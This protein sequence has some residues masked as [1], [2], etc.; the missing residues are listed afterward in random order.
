MYRCLI[1]MLNC[2]SGKQNTTY[3]KMHVHCHGGLL[4]FYLYIL[5]VIGFT[6][7]S[8]R[9]FFK[10]TYISDDDSQLAY[11]DLLGWGEGGIALQVTPIYSI[12][13]ADTQTRTPTKQVTK[14]LHFKGILFFL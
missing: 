13:A 8:L 12:L 10:Q 1:Q 3:H 7:I 14:C 11:F 2:M 4:Y 5:L 9:L 6:E